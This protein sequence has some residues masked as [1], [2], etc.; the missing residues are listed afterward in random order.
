L[1]GKNMDIMQALIGFPAEISK[2]YFDQFIVR[3]ITYILILSKYYVFIL[4][5]NVYNLIELLGDIAFNLIKLITFCLI[6]LFISMF[7]YRM[8]KD[9]GLAILPFDTSNL[10]ENEFSGKSISDLL[11]YDLNEIKQIQKYDFNSM[12]LINTEKIFLPP[13]GP[14][15]ETLDYSI[16]EMGEVGVGDSKIS[17]GRLLITLKMLFGRPGKIITGS[18]G[19]YDK[20]LRIVA[21]LGGAE[22]RFWDVSC[23]LGELDVPGKKIPELVNDLAY[24]IAYEFENKDKNSAKTW[25]ALKHFTKALNDIIL[26][27]RINKIEILNNAA[28]KC[29]EA[30]NCEPGYEKPVDLLSIIGFEYIK[31]EDFIN[32]WNVFDHIEK[33][34]PEITKLAQGLM[35]LE[36]ENYKDAG[37]CFEKVI[38]LNP[39]IIE[40]WFGRYEVL[41]KTGNRDAANQAMGRVLNLQRPSHATWYNK[42][43]AE[44]ILSYVYLGAEDESSDEII[45]LFILLFCNRAIEFDPEC[46]DA[47]Y[48]KGFFLAALKESN[49]NFGEIEKE[50]PSYIK[51]DTVA[52]QKIEAILQSLEN[53]DPLLYF[54]KAIKLNPDCS[55]AWLQRGKI[56]AQ[57]KEDHDDAL[58]S[59]DKVIELNQDYIEAKTIYLGDSQPLTL[60]YKDKNILN[61]AFYQKGI[62]LSSLERYPEA[63]E[64]YKN[65]IKGYL[66][67]PEAYD[68]LIISLTKLGRT[69]EADNEKIPAA[70]AW[71]DKGKSLADKNEAIWCFDK[72]I[73]L[74]PNLFNAY[75]QK[76]LAL[77]S[78]NRHN[79]AIEVYKK[80]IE[81]SKI[82][83]IKSIDTPINKSRIKFL[84]YLAN[85]E[86][87]YG[88]L[89]DSEAKYYAL[90]HTGASLKAMQ[91]PDNAL[92]SY[93]EAIKLD[94]DFFIA[95]FQK[96]NLLATL[97]RD[98]E[99]VEAYQEAIKRIVPETV[100]PECVKLH[101]G[102]ISSLSR[103]RRYEEAAL[104]CIEEGKSLADK[105]KAIECFNK[106]IQLNPK[107]EDA[108]L[109]KGLAL[110][111]QN[112][113]V[114]AIEA[115]EKVLELVPGAVLIYPQIA[116]S[117]YAL[118]KNDEG[119]KT[120]DN[121][122][123]I[124]QDK[125]D[126]NKKISQDENTLS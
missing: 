49:T 110:A 98:E 84:A 20:Q 70:L 24:E 38:E 37:E 43:I 26:Y 33:C 7:F 62:L 51:D 90:V 86:L 55:K 126:R 53:D 80:I 65:A 58:K 35:H 61:I 119:D 59:Y 15:T 111:S 116:N 97:N 106:A 121:A 93:E 48:Q 22:K 75:L 82:I 100:D 19:K 3:I 11:T 25:K 123:K 104:A 73:Q 117:L 103:L 1:A 29:F 81:I 109:Q 56:L 52:I 78:Q 50:L 107:L 120:V 42:K 44:R 118:G 114:E 54:E 113:H 9:T 63:I 18:L 102:L 74:N 115:Y 17:L 66:P 89:S 45:K 95:Y 14:I 71:I 28:S 16:A 21:Y 96:G 124:L 39:N 76:G 46:V 94:P 68:E 40:A 87:K 88:S 13:I 91:K 57:R 41:S 101:E 5:F 2:I 32:A 112:R 72:A 10:G 34:R 36:V 47:Y 125:L 79:E 122:I 12:W 60:N 99:A 77:A 92:E 64:A 23:T 105:N 31:N 27:S 4:N 8:I 85:R 69:E 83:K 108:Y 67:P 30:L 6:L